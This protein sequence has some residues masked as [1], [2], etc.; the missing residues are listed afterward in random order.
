LAP[1]PAAR[2]R[3]YGRIATI[4]PHRE[5]IVVFGLAAGNSQ[6]LLGQDSMSETTGIPALFKA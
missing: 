2:R 5:R 1:H 3:R 4:R 6:S